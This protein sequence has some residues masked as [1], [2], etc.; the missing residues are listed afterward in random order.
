[1]GSEAV[2][3]VRLM[4][5]NLQATNAHI[6]LDHMIL[7]YGGHKSTFFAISGCCI[8]NSANPPLTYSLHK[9]AMESFNPFRVQ[10][11]G[12]PSVASHR[13]ASKMPLRSSRTSLKHSLTVYNAVAVTNLQSAQETTTIFYNFAIGRACSSSLSSSS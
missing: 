12:C 8:S 10:S 13:R 3:S 2:H 7:D 6:M 11:K 1:M 4:N 9:T 5:G